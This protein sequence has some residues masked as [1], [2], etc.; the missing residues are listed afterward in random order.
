[1]KRNVTAALFALVVVACGGASV[2]SPTG[3]PTATPGGPAGGTP[4]VSVT[5][6]PTA[7]GASIDSCALLSDDEI[8]QATGR[9]V[10]SKTPGPAI[11]T[12]AD[13]C[14]WELTQTSDDTVPWSID[15]G[16]MASGGRS[17]FDTYLSSLEGTDPVTGVGDAAVIDGAGGIT[18]VKRDTLI[19]VLVIAFAGDEETITR[20]LAETA[21]SH[22]P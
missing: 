1:M 7:G 15:I 2:A 18:A 12:F 8:A 4:S 21:L 10:A 17:Y 9:Q 16:V 19:S 20:A 22:I 5:V 3:A 11:G 6:A 14:S 13:S